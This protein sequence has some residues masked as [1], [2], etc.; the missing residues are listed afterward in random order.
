[1]DVPPER[2][3]SARNDVGDMTLCE[4]SDVYN[5]P[6]SIVLEYFHK[7]KLNSLSSKK[8]QTC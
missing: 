8:D 5:A 3:Y 4:R 6:D 1:M 7:I 2:R